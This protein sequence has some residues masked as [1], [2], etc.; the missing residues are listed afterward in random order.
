MKRKVFVDCMKKNKL[1]A[2]VFAAATVLNGAVFL[3]YDVMKEPFIYAEVLLL[4][5]LILLFGIDYTG[6]LRSACLRED[7]KNSILLSNSACGD[8]LRDTDYFEMLS[9]LS[10]EI[11][12]L[13]TD[14]S[15]KKHHR[16]LLVYPK[17]TNIPFFQSQNRNAPWQKE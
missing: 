13:Q 4:T 8:T 12:R 9:A 2:V 11:N 10:A 5:V 3:L 14:F 6:E 17:N 7:Q 16:H 1:A 15:V